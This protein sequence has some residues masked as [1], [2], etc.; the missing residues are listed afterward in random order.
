MG[1]LPAQAQPAQA[2]PAQSCQP[3]LPAA[4]DIGEQPG[5]IREQHR[6]TEQW[7][8]QKLLGSEKLGTPVKPARKG[9][10]M[11]VLSSTEHYPLPCP[12]QRAW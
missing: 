5:D 6:D 12:F 11:M 10:A 3:L 8:A 9:A 4:G 1:E 7:K 2:Q